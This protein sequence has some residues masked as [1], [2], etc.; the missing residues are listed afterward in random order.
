[1]ASLQGL[2]N[3]AVADF[4]KL[5]ALREITNYDGSN[6]IPTRETY[7]TAQIANVTDDNLAMINSFIAQRSVTETNTAAKV[8][9]LVDAVNKLR[10]GVNPSL[11]SP[12]S[13]T[14]AEL[15]TLDVAI[16]NNP[17]ALQ[18]MNSVLSGLT[19][20]Q[21]NTFSELD[22]I[23]E[24]VEAI[25]QISAG[26]EPSKN[27]NDA[28]L[29]LIGLTG[30]SS[31][32][33]SA[34]L[35]MIS[36]S[37][38]DGSGVNTVQKLQQLV[39]AASNPTAAAAAQA[40]I[41]QFDGSNQAPTVADY[42]ATGVYG[43]S[44]ENLALV[45]AIV[46][47]ALAVET[48]TFAK[49]QAIVNAVTKLSELVDGVAGTGFSLTLADLVALGLDTMGMEA[50]E[51][52]L[53]NSALDSMFPTQADSAAE[54]Q[55]AINAV[56]KIMVLASGGDPAT[57]LTVEDFTALGLSGVNSEN[58]LMVSLKIKQTEPDGSGADSIAEVNALIQAV[59]AEIAAAQS[60]PMIVRFVEGHEVSEPAAID[61]SLANVQATDSN[62]AIVNQLLAMRSG[63][64]VDTRTKLQALVGTIA[65]SHDA[66]TG[67]ASGQG[68]APSL[69]HFE[70]L[71]IRGLTTQNLAAMN[72]L[73]S[74]LDP[75]ELSTL[76]AIQA[77]VAGIVIPGSESG[78]GG[79]PGSGSNL[80]N[81]E[82]SEVAIVETGTGLVIGFEAGNKVQ[83]LE[84]RLIDSQGKLRRIVVSAANANATLLE[85]EKGRTYKIEI[86]AISKDGVL[87][88][89]Y[90]TTFDSKP[91]PPTDLDLQREVGGRVGVSWSAPAGFVAKY[92]I[93]V[94][95]G[96]KVI[97]ELFSTRRSILLEP[98][99]GRA[100][101]SIFSVG[102]GGAEVKAGES[103]VSPNT[104]I[105][106]VTARKGTSQSKTLISFNAA[107]EGSP[108]YKVYL[109]GK[110][111]CATKLTSC[112]TGRKVG[113]LDK[114][115]VTSSD[116][117]V[118]PLTNYFEALSFTGQVT[119]QPNTA[120]PGPGFTAT[121]N[122]IV[123]DLKK[124]KFTNV[125][126]TGHANQV[127]TFQTA[128]AKRLA[129]LRGEYVAAQLR[130]LLPGVNVV[131]VDRGV[132]SSLVRGNNLRNIRAEIYGTN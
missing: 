23:A 64:E 33:L 79:T 46:G 86:R 83:N 98:F 76:E 47:P 114:L 108:T 56:I 5:A 129:R 60:L 54:L 127:G 59:V 84:I 27:L 104:V 109:N 107:S 8:Q 112:T 123:A 122:K 44:E 9:A 7:L 131:S 96:G 111:V 16:G 21:M 91:N 15:E 11:L 41:E 125:V 100:T 29:A 19:I 69:S 6:T 95:Q 130:K 39:V 77:L 20:D 26:L 117:A 66:I 119:F 70:A 99:N 103:Q 68:P 101:V 50:N 35:S 90:K 93:V 94:E 85:I 25:L 43:V 48:N 31:G 63:I 17:N 13:L 113:P 55:A 24:I 12:D 118:S 110:F 132:E 81:A 72:A 34:V 121:L 106:A 32:N 28:D 61:Y 53:L 58:L 30:V 45:N 38:A 2:I 10:A 37:A 52:S 75:S 124:S 82:I 40:I 22:E 87:G 42:A 36:Q 57:E 97:Q 105:G 67:F 65:S 120:R 71:G 1:V 14:L 128:S 116:G 92:R 4:D 88:E 73:I 18:L 3:E 49:V 102:E 78:I 126:V 62:V 74:G 51:L 89:P 80:A 115:K